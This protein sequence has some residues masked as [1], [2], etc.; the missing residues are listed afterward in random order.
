MRQDGD[1]RKVPMLAEGYERLTA[2]LK[3]LR[4]ERPQD[5]R[6]DRGSARPRRPVGE[7][8]VS[9]RQGAPGPGRGAD[10]RYRGPGQPRADHR[11][12]D[13]VGRP[14]RVRRDRHRCSTTTTSRSRYQIVGQTEADAKVGPDLLQLAA[15]PRA[16]R[17]QGRR[18]DRGHGALGRPVLRG[19]ED[20]VHLTPAAPGETGASSL[21]Q[22][23][24][25]Q[26][27]QVDDDVLH[28]GIVDRALRVGRARRLRRCRSRETRR[29]CRDSRGR[30]NRGLCGS[31]TRPPM[32]R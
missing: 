25:E 29:R 28:L 11:S 2:D 23:R 26:P 15:R 21:R 30:R 10:R 31:L 18:R 1:D 16:D 7:R 32:T 4:E 24:L 14:D 20:R 8:R 5:R 19:R 9:R 17:Q 3:A 6:R 22:L 27:V 12:G 13:A